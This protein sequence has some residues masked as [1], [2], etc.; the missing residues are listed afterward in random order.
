MFKLV[1]SDD[2]GKTTVVP[3]VR[4][5]V[6]IGRKDGNTIRL[7]ERNVSRKH[8]TLRRVN[9]GFQIEDLNS[10]NGVQINGRRIGEATP[11]EPGDK[12]VIGDYVLALEAEQVLPEDAPTEV[13]TSGPP[14]RLVMLS[15]PAPGAE[16]A[17]TRDGIRLGR[18]EDLEIWINHRSIS[19]E[20]AEIRLVGEEV[21]LRDLQS[22]NGLRVNGEPAHDQPLRSGDVIELGQVRFRFVAAGEVYVFEADATL[23]VDA[24]PAEPEPEAKPKTLMIAGA[25]VV[26]ALLV[27]ALIAIPSDDPEVEDEVIPTTPTVATMAT[28]VAPSGELTPDMLIA[29]A[30]AECER[31]IASGAYQDAVGAAGRALARDESSESAQRCLAEAQT[32]QRDGEIF[33]RGVAELLGNDPIAAYATFT[34]LSPDGRYADRPEIARARDGYVSA[35]LAAAEATVGVD[36][37]GAQD[38]AGELLG[39]DD[40][41]RSER[42]RADGVLASAGEAALAM[43]DTPTISRMVGRNPRNPRT[44]PMSTP[45][46]TR[47]SAVVAATTTMTTEMATEPAMTAPQTTA[48]R[49]VTDICP[50]GDANFS[51]CVVDNFGGAGRARD[52]RTL[53]LLI[54]SYTR[55]GRTADATRAMR[56]FV[57]RYPRHQR[58]P[59][60][61]RRLSN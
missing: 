39:R 21:V 52:A 40:L 43:N 37:Q 47:M 44:S 33:E 16:F 3:L 34:E 29:E 35:Q 15:A 56:E 55:L 12:V 45:M 53:G 23:M 26:V 46:S 1:I 25:L 32:A 36:P 31:A 8:A 30:V 14:P 4:D 58:T 9:G 48:M 10:Y 18:A 61:Q 22:A 24:I 42:D 38:I 13:Q 41:S 50:P 6:S 27:G 7:T 57:R 60:F 17:L 20:H 5:E 54:A 51:R 28:D 11:L 49:G 59:G 2:E 19:R